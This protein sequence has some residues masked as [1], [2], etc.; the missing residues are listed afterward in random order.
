MLPSLTAVARHMLAV[1]L[2]ITM[3]PSL[4]AQ[5]G[6]ECTAPAFSPD[7][8]T[9]LFAANP[10]G[11]YDLYTLHLK[12]GRLRQL[13]KHPAN[14]WYAE[15]RPDGAIYFQSDREDTKALYRLD[16]KTKKEERVIAGNVNQVLHYGGA[17]GEF[18]Y[19]TFHTKLAPDGRNYPDRNT[20][21]IIRW[22][23]AKQKGVPLTHNSYMDDAPHLSP[24]G[25]NLAFQSGKGGDIDIFLMDTR[26]RHLQQLTTHPDFDGIPVWSP[27]GSHIAFTRK[28]D[29]NYDIWLMRNDG[30]EA[31]NLSQHP[32]MDLYVA[33]TP[34][35]RH[36][37]FSSWRDG[38]QQIYWMDATTGK[39]QQ[40]LSCDLVF[41]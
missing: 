6:Y 30:S 29:D 32:A 36:I 31:V 16:P 7:G 8:K 15:W 37:A 3:H 10:H 28:T 39:D 17:G 22:D 41:P 34:D 11:Q 40:C 27:D 5:S 14:D 35:G 24:D 19:V 12:S 4:P 38:R 18:Y 21:E 26:G 9:L 33:W 23:A 1:V 25:K 2:L 13:T 20:F